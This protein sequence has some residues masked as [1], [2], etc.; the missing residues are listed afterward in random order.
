MFAQLCPKGLE[1]TMYSI[2]NSIT[3]AGTALADILGSL[4]ISYFGMGNDEL[5]GVEDKQ[6]LAL[7]YRDISVAY[8]SIVFWFLPL[9]P[10]ICYLDFDAAI[11]KAKS[12]D[13]AEEDEV[14]EEY[15]G[16]DTN[17]SR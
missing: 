16:V 9:A 15:S 2:L 3:F 5:C 17:L 14:E 13:E 11:A 8:T 12:Y 6:K 7:C 10:M 4:F 1:G